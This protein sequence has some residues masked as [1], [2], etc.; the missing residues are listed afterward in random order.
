MKSLLF[1]LLV[2]LTLGS[3][4]AAPEAAQNVNPEQA[5]K[6]IA[7]K[8][9]LVVLDVRTPEEFAGGHIA[10][11]KNLDLYAKDF[12]EQLKA[13]DKSKEYLVHCAAGPRSNRVVKMMGDFSKVYQLE[14]GM[15]AWQAAGQPVEK[16]K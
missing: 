14:G 4:Y 9:D 5:S 8:K 12:A 15:H 11:A 6:L 7:E 16:S 2:S 10:G 3:V 1:F 13:L